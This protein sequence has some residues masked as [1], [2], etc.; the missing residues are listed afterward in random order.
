VGT[1]LDAKFYPVLVTSFG[2]DERTQP[3][4]CRLTLYAGFATI[5]SMR[6]NLIGGGLCDAS[7]FR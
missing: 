6:S 3:I 4:L 1:V 2:D 7:G 5:G